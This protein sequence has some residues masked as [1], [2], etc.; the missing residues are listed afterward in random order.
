MWAVGTKEAAVAV[1]NPKDDARLVG[2]PK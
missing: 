1:L 2:V